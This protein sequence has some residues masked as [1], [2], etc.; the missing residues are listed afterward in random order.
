MDQTQTFVLRR[1]WIYTAAKFA[2]L[3]SV[4][5]LAPLFS[6]QAITGSIVNATL[7]VSVIL[8]GRQ[9]AILIGLLPSLISLSAGLLVFALAPM[10]PFIMAGNVI[11][12]LIFHSL[13]K[14]K[15]WLGVISAAFLKFVFLAS[16]SNMI[17]GSFLKKEIAG[18]AAM[19]FSW[20]QLFTAMAGGL[21]AYLFLK[22]IKKLN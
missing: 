15:Y 21:I 5:S 22:S 14:R 13:S 9:N 12:I 7:F 20:P 11:L 18:Q 16:T 19:M 4:A 1:E 8:L 3:L 17:T 6:Q 10:V 2:A